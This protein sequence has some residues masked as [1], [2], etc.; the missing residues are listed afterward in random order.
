[1]LSHDKQDAAKVANAKSIQL[2][3]LNRYTT[4]GGQR[5]D[6]RVM[7][8]PG[9]MVVPRHLS[10][11]EEGNDFAAQ[12]VQGF[13]FGE[14]MIV[15]SLAGKG[16]ILG[17][18]RPATCLRENMLDGMK[19]G[20]E[21]F[22]TPAIFATP[23]RPAMN[24]I[25][26]FLCHAQASGLPVYQVT[27]CQIRHH[28]IQGQAPQLGQPGHGLQPFG[29]G[30]LQPI[31]QGKQFLGFCFVEEDVLP[32]GPEFLIPLDPVRI[33]LLIDLPE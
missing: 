4:C 21:L 20:C 32:F 28:V 29:V 18:I 9:K 15:A 3:F 5:D 26:D 27:N 16:Q 22:R 6:L 19:L 24:Q 10:G 31:A 13:R 25:L 33:R 23:P 17:I 1:M 11:M 7:V 8:T 2:K 14:F 12:V 30:F